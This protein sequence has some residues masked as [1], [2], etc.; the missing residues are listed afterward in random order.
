MPYI[1]TSNAMIQC[2]H[3]GVVKPV[4]KQQTVTIQ[5]G[6]ILCHP[7]LVGAVIEGC[8]QPVSSGSKPCTTVL[9]VLPGCASLEVQVAQR[10]AYVATLSALTD[11]IPSATIAVRSPGQTVVQG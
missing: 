3:G 4:P 7:D 5:G 10:P 6:A 8:P 11:G 2:P 9:S 1:V